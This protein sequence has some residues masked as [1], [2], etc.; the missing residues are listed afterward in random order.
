MPI[1][2]YHQAQAVPAGSLLLESLDARV[3]L[4]DVDSFAR[5]CQRRLRNLRVSADGSH[6][7]PPDDG[8]ATAAGPMLSG[9]L[10]AATWHTNPRSRLDVRVGSKTVTLPRNFSWLVAGEVCIPPFLTCSSHVT[11]FL[12]LRLRAP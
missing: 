8:G 10:N 11:R 5:N 7:H 6:A 3:S 4:P 9:P 1:S 12:L 2:L